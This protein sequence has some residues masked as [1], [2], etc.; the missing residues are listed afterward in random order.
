[1][2][3][4]RAFLST[5]PSFLDQATPPIL[6]GPRTRPIRLTEADRSTTIAPPSPLGPSIVSQKSSARTQNVTHRAASRRPISDRNFGARTRADSSLARGLTAQ[7]PG[8]P[9]YITLS[10]V[11]GRSRTRFPVALN[12]ALATAAPTPV[13]PISP[14]PRAPTG[15][16]GSGSS[17]Q[18]TSISGTSRC[19]GT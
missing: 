1:M 15:A 2:V 12:T 8:G 9:G 17:V 5:H 6:P 13:M 3:I 10:R 16:C 11:I 4:H 19:T 14:T 18:I 7:P